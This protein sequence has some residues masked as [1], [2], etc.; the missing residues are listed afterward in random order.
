SESTRCSP[1]PTPGSWRVTWGW[2][3]AKNRWVLRFARA[4][5]GIAY[6]SCG[7][8]SST[9]PRGHRDPIR[10]TETKE[11]DHEICH[12]HRARR[13][14]ARLGER[15]RHR[16]E[17]DHRGAPAHGSILRPEPRQPQRRGG[18]VPANPR[19]RARRVRA[20]DLQRPAVACRGTALHA[21]G[22]P[23]RRLRGEC[24]TADRLL[25]G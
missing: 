13:R 9:A 19:R 16:R 14:A 22:D 3:V 7:K 25:P 2:Y 18:A 24:A 8:G 1:A 23:A 6:S 5:R 10:L 15:H 21:R 12:P 4:A 17:P 11:T 20:A